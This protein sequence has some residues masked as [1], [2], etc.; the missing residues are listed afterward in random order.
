MS[1]ILGTLFKYLVSLLGVAAVVVILY[2]VFGANKT[3]NAISDITLLQTNA[4]A[5]YSAQN[6]FTSL[7]TAVAIAGKLA[8]TGMI[9]GT[10][11]VNPW[12][13]TVALNVNAGNATQFDITEPGVPA[14]ACA[15]MIVGLST[16]V[17]L[18]VNAVAQK[19][20][21]DAGAAVTACNVAANT[22][23]FTFA[24]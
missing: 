8:P 15:K 18:T 17:A 16:A 22:L 13:G 7:T 3:S 19:L 23:V 20:P 2:Q 11:L 5:L 24:R 4:Q 10:S 6:S 12:G 1:E 14:D 21:L 9:S